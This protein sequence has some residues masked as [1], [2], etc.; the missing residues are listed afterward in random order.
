MQNYPFLKLLCFS[1]LLFT[2]SCDR[3]DD[4][5]Q[6]DLTDSYIQTQSFLGCTSYTSTP[7]PLDNGSAIDDFIA[8]GDDWYI[9]DYDRQLLWINTET[10]DRQVLLDDVSVGEL[11][12]RS[13]RV[14]VC[15]D[16]GLY[17]ISSPGSLVKLSDID[18]FDTEVIDDRLWL[19]S[20]GS[21]DFPNNQIYEYDFE[22]NRLVTAQA[23]LGVNI[24]RFKVL[25]TGEI[26]IFRT[27]VS[28]TELARVVDGQVVARYA[29]GESPLPE[30]VFSFDQVW[31]AEYD[32][33]IVVVAK[34]GATVPLVMRYVDGKW[35]ELMGPGVRSME[36]ASEKEL[37]I[38]LPSIKEVFVRD[39]FLYVLTSFAGC[40]GIHRYDLSGE[41]ALGDEDFDVFEDRNL[42]DQ[43]LEGYFEPQNGRGQ[44]Y[45]YSQQRVT[46]I[47]G[48]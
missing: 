17:E 40:R 4:D 36:G 31:L 1:L 21:N 44:I 43:C 10:R 15:S 5:V 45:I 22:N 46:F 29:N 18:C 28:D 26:W 19:V 30:N 37:A 32:G 8:I 39:N 9:G 42:P 7:S 25:S 3:E 47:D 20:S 11:T 6:S 41:E 27:Q 38:I 34:N 2:L 14:Y 48:C 24:R 13:G 35:K 33:S 16:R 23:D 12:V